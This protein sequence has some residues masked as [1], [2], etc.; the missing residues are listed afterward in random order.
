[1]HGCAAN[2]GPP[3]GTRMRLTQHGL[4]SARLP[5]NDFRNRQ[6]LRSSHMTAG[7]SVTGGLDGWQK[8]ARTCPAAQA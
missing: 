6:C 3:I 4:V 7:L 8:P 1:M 5:G 2:S